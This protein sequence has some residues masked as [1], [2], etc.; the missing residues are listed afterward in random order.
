MDKEQRPFHA[1]LSTAAAFF[2]LLALLLLGGILNA[3]WEE[4]SVERQP[5][6]VVATSEQ[7]PVG[8]SESKGAQKLDDQEVFNYGKGLISLNRSRADIE[9]GMDLLHHLQESSPRYDEAQA[10]LL[11]AQTFLGE[12][13]KQENRGEMIFR[14]IKKRYPQTEMSWW[15]RASTALILPRNEWNRLSKLDQISLTRYVEQANGYGG[16]WTI[17]VG[18]P[19]RQNELTVDRTVVQ[20]DQLWEADDPCCRGKK[21]TGFRR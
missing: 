6:P 15:G 18:D 5:P 12:I 16:S 20:A 13:E 7:E 21:A 8:K 19:I 14:A 4:R 17:I 11:K 10:L 9:E 3:V 1:R 2:I